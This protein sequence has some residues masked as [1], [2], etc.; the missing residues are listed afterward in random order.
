MQGQ[1][2]KN[3]CV[4]FL[5]LLTPLVWSQVS[6][7]ELFTEAETRF[8]NKDY[9]LALDR[10]DALLTRYPLS[11]YVPDAQFR[12]AVCVYR[13]GRV[14]EALSLFQRV[15]NRYRSTRFIDFVPFW[16]GVI[17]YEQQQ[18]EKAVASLS[19][20]IDSG[21]DTELMRQARLYKGLSLIYSQ[22][23]SEAVQTLELLL[24]KA[25]NKEAEGYALSLLFTLY[26]KSRAY[27]KLLSMSEEIDV[28]K[29]DPAFRD[30][31]MFFTAEA[32]WAK[33][34]SEEAESL[35]RRLT[36]AEAEIAS[37]A[38]SRLFRTVQQSGN[39]EALT[40]LLNKAEQSLAGKTTYLK[41]FWLQVGIISYSWERYGLSEL[42]FSRV[43]NLRGVE[44]ISGS[45]PLYYSRLL[46]ARGE[47]DRAAEV[48]I[49]YLAF[50]DEY[51]DRILLSLGSIYA[52]KGDFTKAITYLE[53]FSEKE[54]DSDLYSQGM[55][56]YAYALNKTGNAEET[57]RVI[58]SVERE[59][60]S[61]GLT[62]EFLRLKASAHRKRAHYSEAAE[63]L[64]EYLSL[65]P[66]DIE[67]SLEY[68]KMLF[69]REEYSAV[70]EEIN[71]L[72]GV[73]PELED[74]YSQVYL[75]S[76]Y[77]L[78]LSLIT[79]KKYRE[80][81]EPLSTL[82]EKIEEMREEDAI[83]DDFRT[84]YPYALF[85]RGW[86]LYRLS[87][88]EQALNVFERFVNRYPEHQM[89]HNA[90]YLAGWNAFIDNSLSR[91]ENMLRKL[92]GKEI[93]LELLEKTRYLL[94]KTLLG[95]GKY[96]EALAEFEYVKTE[97][98]SDIVPQAMFEYA[99][100]LLRMDR[101]Q[102]AADEYLALFERF[103][104][105]PS[106]E[107][108]LYQ[109]GEIYYAA[110]RYEEAREAFAEYRARFPLGDLFDD[111]LFWGGSAAFTIDK[112]T[113]AVLLWGILIDEYRDSAYRPEAM[114]RSA[115][116]YAEQG[117]YRKAMNLYTELIALYP[118]AAEEIN[119]EDK[120]NVLRYLVLGLSEREAELWVT[121]DNEGGANTKKGRQAVI[122]LAQLY[123]I[124][125]QQQT[126]S[127]SLLVEKVKAVAAKTEEDPSAAAQAE[128]LLG[129]YYAENAE[130]ARAANT[131]INAAS[132]HPED[133]DLITLSLYRGLETLKRI[134]R[135][136]EAIKLLERLQ[137]NFPDSPWTL[138]AERLLEGN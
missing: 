51:R 127:S 39:D 109:R 104:A 28:Q 61:G 133:K 119:A 5:L 12:K 18:Y 41:N 80:A 103:P 46:E 88:Y 10:Y 96:R 8:R 93:S 79:K 29:I 125:D 126:L 135:N 76:R 106:A 64:H 66:K 118:E 50:G 62:A 34:R 77:L 14:D 33:S 44:E 74:E 26:G 58:E 72:D 17:L 45:V 36:G 83:T 7:Q 89:T 68:I 122:E 78:G 57:V 97:G 16:K 22:K 116:Y 13:L 92:S 63:A 129:E 11:Q 132:I 131:F 38:F 32:L 42:Y 55:Y 19:L 110:G 47:R 52:E 117:G 23:E 136:D 91:A 3:V 75:E 59:G 100:V 107:T 48:L 102:E 54:A 99:G 108:G 21:K 43:W 60:L 105:S 20:F 49:E 95:R 94:G 114:N 9:E 73:L 35:Y 27:E 134:G 113:G 4:F 67:A 111:A 84:I 112:K 2:M 53:Q 120:A 130:Y 138:Q 31:I 81:V 124:E 71:N 87:L 37:V 24:Q 25:D 98:T 56:Q 65:R 30:R 121:I 123:I 82:T 101:L 69:V 70:I 1:Y 40:E 137:D 115:E 85:Y 90:L 86:S 15:E 6:E 128:Y